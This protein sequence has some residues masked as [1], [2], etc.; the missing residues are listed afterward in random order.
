[1]RYKQII[2]ILIIPLLCCCSAKTFKEPTPKEI[3]VKKDESFRVNLSENHK[4]G[5]TWQLDE[6]YNREIIE[7]KNSVW[8]GNENGV[9]FYFKPIKIGSTEITFIERKYDS[10]RNIKTITIFVK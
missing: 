1:M 3:T 8:E 6:S 7:Y 4:D 2:H 5:F 9:F 10:I